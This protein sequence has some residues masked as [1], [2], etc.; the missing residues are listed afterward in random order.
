MLRNMPLRRES[1]QTLAAFVCS[2]LLGTAVLMA[3]QAQERESQFTPRVYVGAGVGVTQLE[4]KT[5]N[6]ALTVSEDTDTGFHVA[7]G[8]D[9]TSRLSA[10]L[11]YADLGAAEIDFL[12]SNVGDIGYQ[13]FG[14]SGLVYL[15]NSRSGLRANNTRSGM[16]TREGFSLF[17]RVGVGGI[18]ADSELDHV[19]NNNAHLA[20][21]LGVEYGFRN[22]F[23]VRGEYQAFDSDAQY[24]TLS[25][26]KRFGKLRSAAV[27][28]AAVAS[29]P[30]P[31]ASA[32][33][34]PA[35]PVAPQ[36]PTLPSVPTVNFDFDKSDIT[37]IAANKLDEVVAAVADSDVRLMLEGHTDWIATESYNFDL[38]MRRTESVRRY[39]ES[40]G[41][42]RSRMSVRGFGEKR[43][44]A[45]NA[46]A[47][48]RAINRRV[49]IRIQ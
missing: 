35:A 42:A 9:F 22:G 14:L 45:S 29:V 17:G 49:D 8:Y 11:Y 25:L 44:I 18:T 4:P 40:K 30:T 5:P 12:G 20:L 15:Y 31:I 38:S 47:E 21:G 32:P 19:V 7:V 26:V 36:Q 46:T 1:G 34:A 39:L 6:D 3:A 37:A 2:V 23:A 24:A 27:P 28:V 13:V 33:V 10:E 41:I 43:P 16:G 48:G